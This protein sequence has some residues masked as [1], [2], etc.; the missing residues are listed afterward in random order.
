MFWDEDDNDIDSTEDLFVDDE[1]IEE[2][3]I[4]VIIRVRV[5]RDDVEDND[6]D[7]PEEPV[8]PRMPFFVPEGEEWSIEMC[9]VEISELDHNAPEILELDRPGCP[10][11]I[12]GRHGYRCGVRPIT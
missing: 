5:L 3:R 10:W 12:Q 8:I 1:E 11:A 9:L 2:Q 4:S 7:S 6:W